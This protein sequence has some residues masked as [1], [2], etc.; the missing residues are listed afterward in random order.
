MLDYVW[1]AMAR[2]NRRRIARITYE[3]VIVQGDITSPL[4]RNAWRVPVEEITVD[5]CALVGR[6]CRTSYSRKGRL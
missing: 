2:L 3:N 4:H 1:G 5:V 6:R